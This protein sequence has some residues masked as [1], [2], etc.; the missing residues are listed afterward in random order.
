MT[1]EAAI[2][3]EEILVDYEHPHGR[4]EGVKLSDLLS[5]P[6]E[7][8]RPVMQV[9]FPRNTEGQPL[10]WKLLRKRTKNGDLIDARIRWSSR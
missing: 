8:S 6:A 2:S 3:P 10:D 5:T 7:S 1:P 4:L 9:S